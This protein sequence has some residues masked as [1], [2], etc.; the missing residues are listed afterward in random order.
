MCSFE[1]TI[2]KFRQCIEFLRP[3]QHLIDCHVVEFFT[4]NLFEKVPKTLVKK[5]ST[6]NEKN[7]QEFENVF[8]LK[9]YTLDTFPEVETIRLPDRLEQIYT[10]HMNPKKIHEVAI[11][12]Q[13]IALSVDKSKERVIIDAGCGLAY[14]SSWLAFN[15]NFKVVGVDARPLNSEFAEKRLKKFAKKVKHLRMK[16]DNHK[17][18][19]EFID[20]QT[21]FHRIAAL[22]FPDSTDP[23]L[24]L[25][26]LHTCGALSNN[27]LKIFRNVKEIDELFNVGCCYN[28]LQPEDFPMSDAGHGEQF[29]LSRN[30]RMLAAYSAERVFSNPDLSNVRKIFYRTL[31]EKLLV[32]LYPGAQISNIG[33]IKGDSFVEY[34]LNAQNTRPDLFKEKQIQIAA[35]QAEKCYLENECHWN[36]MIIFYLYRMS[37]AP[38]IESAIILDKV[39]YLLESQKADVKLVKLFDPFISPRCY[40]MQAN[41]KRQQ[42]I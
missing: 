4:G 1:A 35:E 17:I 20:E 36:E 9:E 23:M 10:D 27:C 32:E 18:L 31:L 26:G 2:T 34:V 15:Y 7:F 11:M 6:L 33:P 38:V 14:L 8:S 25:T 24:T 5:C 30:S 3:S 22:N 12:A 42:A 40:L 37:F 16:S 13:F 39:I 28:L 29:Y 41:K 21:N 19:T